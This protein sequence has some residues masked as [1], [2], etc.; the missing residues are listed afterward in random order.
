MQK[1]SHAFLGFANSIIYI[2]LHIEL[3]EAAKCVLQRRSMTPNSNNDEL[4]SRRVSTVGGSRIVNDGIGNSNRTV[5]PM[6]TEQH[7][8]IGNVSPKGRRR[9]STIGNREL[10]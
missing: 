5:L 4:F 3:G 1:H 10:F 6:R 9:T 2:W 8:E 7:N